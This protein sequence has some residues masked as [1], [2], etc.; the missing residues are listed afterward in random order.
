MDKFHRHNKVVKMVRLLELLAQMNYGKNDGVADGYRFSANL[1]REE[2]N[3][4]KE[5]QNE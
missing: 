4:P 3:I 5:E 1:I 2:F